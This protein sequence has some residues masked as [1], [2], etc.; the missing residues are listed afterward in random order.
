MPYL[1][2][3]PALYPSPG[4]LQSRHDLS[5]WCNIFSLK[6]NS[7]NLAKRNII[8][9]CSC[10]VNNTCT[11]RL[12]EAKYGIVLL[13]VFPALLSVGIGTAVQVGMHFMNPVPVMKLVELI[14]GMQT[15]DEV[16]SHTGTQVATPIHQR[17]TK[18]ICI[19]QPHVLSVTCSLGW[20]VSLENVCC[21]I[22]ALS[23]L[24]CLSIRPT[25]FCL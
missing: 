7:G 14:R 13:R 21:K 22:S 20:W 24:C 6:S 18:N 9:M 15:S 19:K 25:S 11:N 17:S 12:H 1:R 4:L 23:L 16:R 2:P 10:S 8:L 5:K 3:T